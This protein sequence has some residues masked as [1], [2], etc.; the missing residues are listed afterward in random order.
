MRKETRV[1]ENKIV[2]I[3]KFI[4]K[5]DGKVGIKTVETDVKGLTYTTSDFCKPAQLEARTY[6]NKSSS[7]SERWKRTRELEAEIARLKKSK[8]K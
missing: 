5:R 1:M 7:E 3:E 2:K 8:W 4:V 6:L